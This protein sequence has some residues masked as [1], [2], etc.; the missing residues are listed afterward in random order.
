MKRLALL[1]CALGV[2][3]LTCFGQ[4]TVLP[5]QQGVTPPPASLSKKIS[6]PAVKPFEIKGTTESVSLADPSKGIRPEITITGEDG[7]RHTFLVRATTTI[8]GQDW[9]AIALD[10]LEKGQQVRIQYITNKDGM[11][12]ALSIKPVSREK[13]Q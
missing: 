4:D 6:K 10:K 1:I 9:K 11:P 2:F 7:K 5:V 3:S 12:V 13:I 8:Y